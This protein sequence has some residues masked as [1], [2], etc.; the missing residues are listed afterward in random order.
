MSI[1]VLDEIKNE[2][3]KQD[4]RVRIGKDYSGAIL[5]L[6]LVKKQECVGKDYDLYTVC[7]VIDNGVGER[8]FEK[9]YDETFTDKQIEKFYSNPRFHMDEEEEEEYEKETTTC[10]WCGV[11]GIPVLEKSNARGF[12]ILWN[13]SKLWKRNSC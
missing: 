3:G 9:L 6:T 11:E 7:K 10:I 8:T 12:R 5:K 13:M 2:E 4:Y 1:D